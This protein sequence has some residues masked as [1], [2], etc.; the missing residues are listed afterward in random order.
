MKGTMKYPKLK[1]DNGL[2]TASGCFPTI[3][4]RSPTPFVLD[5]SSTLRVRLICDFLTPG[6]I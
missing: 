6:H 2:S 1:L 3:L 5:E 4:Q